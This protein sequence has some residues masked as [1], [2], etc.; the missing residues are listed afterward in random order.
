MC[1]DAPTRA[2]ALNFGLRGDI[3]D[4]ITHANFYVNRFRGFGVLTPPILLF[5]IG[6]AGR[7]YNSVSTN[8]IFTICLKLH[9]DGERNICIM[10]TISSHY[11]Y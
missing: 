10:I 11:Y 1:Q 2:I 7:L 8:V 9:L 6:L 4:I 5:S 3:A